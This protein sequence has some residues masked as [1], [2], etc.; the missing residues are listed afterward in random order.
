MTSYVPEG[1]LIADTN[2]ANIAR[3]YIAGEFWFDFIPWLPIFAFAEDNSRESF[4]R[5]FFIVKVMRI[6][7]GLRMLDVMALM[8]H[9]KSYS[10]AR[11]A[12]IIENDPELA[13]D[14]LH[15]NNN[16]SALIHVNL[17]LKIGRLALII[18]V[19][20]YFVG[21]IFFIYSDIVYE[22]CGLGGW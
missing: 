21:I 5:L 1:E 19:V 8:E 13:E 18:L 20:S 6:S 15:D 9:I 14:T 7:K 4:W 12:S 16:I 2:H 17:F 22:I 11:I 3:R 10:N